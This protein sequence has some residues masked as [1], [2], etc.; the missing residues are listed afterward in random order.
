[1]IGARIRQTDPQLLYGKGYDHCFILR[2]GNRAMPRLAARACHPKSGRVL[3]IFTTQPGLQFYTGNHLNGSVAGR[4][5]AYRQSAGL[6]FEPQGFPDAP[7]R[8]GFPN[9]IL[10][11]GI[12]YHEVIKYLFS[13]E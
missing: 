2:D 4:D 5:G 10:R 11:P 1:L 8:E 13:T 6:V 12:R 3:E 9:A 7:N